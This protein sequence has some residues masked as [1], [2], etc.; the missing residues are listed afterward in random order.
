MSVTR[1]GARR[2]L[3]KGA[4]TASAAPL[5][6]CSENAVREP[7]LAASPWRIR[8]YSIFGAALGDRGGTARNTPVD[9]NKIFLRAALGDRPRAPSVPARGI[10]KRWGSTE[11]MAR[12]LSSRETP[13]DTADGS[14]SLAPAE[15]ACRAR[16]PDTF[17]RPANAAKSERLGRMPPN[18]NANRDDSAENSA[19]NL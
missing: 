1:F 9:D 10:P 18:N 8:G 3:S 17:D 11:R 14:V 19:R 13:G 2:A 16:W 5:G 7:A 6:P 12:V 4:R 15:P